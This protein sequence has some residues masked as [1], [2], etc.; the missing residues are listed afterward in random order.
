MGLGVSAV[1]GPP[2]ASAN[3]Q[4]PSPSVHLSPLRG[5][6]TQAGGGG[7]CHHGLVSPSCT[8]AAHFKATDRRPLWGALALDDTEGQRSWPHAAAEA[9]H[10]GSALQAEGHFRQMSNCPFLFT[11]EEKLTVQ[12]SVEKWNVRYEW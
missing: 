11:W 6:L 9:S 3:A 12:L 5:S 1:E 10:P 8:A 7:I 2:T 4:P